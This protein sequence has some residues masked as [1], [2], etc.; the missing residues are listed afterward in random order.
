MRSW[1]GSLLGLFVCLVGLVDPARA[2]KDE[3][4]NPVNIAGFRPKVWPAAV[5]AGLYFVSGTLHWIHYFRTGR[6]RYMLT[7]TISMYTTVL[8]YVFRIIYSQG[9]NVYSLPWYLLQSIFILLS[10]CAFIA[11]DY[12]LLQKLADSL[13]EEAAKDCLYLRSSLIVKLFVWS[14]FITFNVQADGAGLEANDKL[15]KIG[16]SIALAGLILQILSFLFFTALLFRF[17]WRARTAHPE[18]W[19]IGAGESYWKDFGFFKVTPFQDWR[20][21]WV[22]MCLTSVA[23]IIR[24]IFRIVEYQGGS[25]GYVMMHEGYSYVLDS[26]P[27]WIAM[28]LYAW[29]WPT[30]LQPV[31]SNPYAMQPLTDEA[32]KAT[33]SPDQEGERHEQPS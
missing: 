3:D 7:L 17:G 29:L 11:V 24:C 8:G 26:L 21:L 14:D 20:I 6:P 23:I 12:V 18:I 33:Q 15:D 22:V 2:I 31:V 27:L 25:R 30:R 28:T 10:P 9:D 16:S 4:G 5:C 19:R 1:T 13:G 32:H